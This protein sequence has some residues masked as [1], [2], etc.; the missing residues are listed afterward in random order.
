MRI[1][2]GIKI[3]AV[4]ASVFLGAG[5]ASGQELIR[6]F[7]GFGPMGAVG[8]LM[9]GVLFALTGWSVLTICRREK[10]T[11]YSGMMQHLLGKR[12]GIATEW[13]VAAF[14]FCLFVAM[15]AGAGATARQAFD[16]PFTAG[17]GIVG[18]VVFIILLFDL[19]GIVK[20]NVILAPLMIFG[21]FFV[22][23]YAFLAASRPAFAMFAGLPSSWVVAAVVYAS[24]NLV[25]GIPVL[26]ATSKL[27]TK[28]SDAFV[29][30]VVGGG[31]ITLLGLSLL[32][33]LFLYY[34]DVVNIEIPLLMIVVNYGPFFSLLYLGVLISA[35]LTTA[36][37]NGFAVLQWLNSH[38]RGWLANRKVAAAA[39]CLLGIG[40]AHIGFSRIVAYVYP[41]FGLLGLF[42][43]LIIILNAI[44]PA[45]GPDT[46]S[47]TPEYPKSR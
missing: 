19:N 38:S 46:A 36:A 17:A 6:Y 3:A 45:T 26:A 33:P 5:F 20:V 31:V 39:L 21:G 10:I 28:K 37:C 18:A 4:Y 12:L 44:Q 1:S 13:L 11:T 47:K 32:L 27:A 14:L 22:G 8:L 9:A 24:Y 2:N 35:L 43:I 29:G 42:M 23:L 41:I 40:A 16:I 25:T 30:G 15:L 7:V 34:T